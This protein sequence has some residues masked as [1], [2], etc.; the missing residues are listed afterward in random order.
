MKFPRHWAKAQ[1]Q[2]FSAWGWSDAS[3]AEAESAARAAVQRIA[4]RFARGGSD[5][6]SRYLYGDRALREQVLEEMQG[7]AI[8]R[9]SYGCE[10]LNTERAMFVDI[11]LPEPKAGGFLGRF[12]GRKPEPDA[13]EAALAKVETWLARNPD[14]GFRVYRTKAGLRLLATHAALDAKDDRS[15]LMGQ[16][17]ADPLYI[18]L[19]AAQKSYRA[20]LTPKPW[21]CD[22]PALA[23]SWPFADIK[24][25]ARFRD[26]REEYAAKARG[27]ATCAFMRAMGSAHADSSVAEVMRHHDERTRA[28][29]GLPLA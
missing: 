26:W 15:Q 18:R 12:L 1:Q 9:N 17:G 11:D 28:A 16:L 6:L 24:A 2:A 25:E 13:A 3:L 29:S 4:E 27:F 21:R 5:A 8:T 23:V 19:C 14:W 20:R 10:V 7:V 22:M